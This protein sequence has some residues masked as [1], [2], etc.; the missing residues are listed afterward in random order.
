MPEDHEITRLVR[1]IYACS[2]KR[3]ALN[4]RI[5]KAKAR[6]FRL[7]PRGQYE[8]GK[9]GEVKGKKIL[10]KEHYRQAF[11]YLKRNKKWF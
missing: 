8:W 4:A 10:V 2:D 11:K 3:D 5:Q 6:L 1:T 9:I 7:A